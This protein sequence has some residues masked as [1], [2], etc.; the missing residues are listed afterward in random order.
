MQSQLVVV[1]CNLTSY[2]NIINC[3]IRSYLMF[4]LCLYRS[5]NKYVFKF[6]SV[7]TVMTL[8][9]DRLFIK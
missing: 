5:T 9:D 8:L 2:N 4:K 7:R 6:L 1:L 3:D